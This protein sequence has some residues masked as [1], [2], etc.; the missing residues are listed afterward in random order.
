VLR[1]FT[2]T[3]RQL[4]MSRLDPLVSEFET[5]EQADSYNRWFEA[6]VL[7]AMNSS[8]PRIPHDEAMARVEAM[9]AEKRKAR[10][11]RPVE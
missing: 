3:E 7:E 4:D 8:K 1:G 9:L 11:S 5:D 6:K 2:A 10:A